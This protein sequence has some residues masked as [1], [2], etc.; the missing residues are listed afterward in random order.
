MYQEREVFNAA[1][2][3]WNMFFKSGFVVVYKGHLAAICKFH[4]ISAVYEQK[5]IKN[6]I[7]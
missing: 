1:S 3:Y 6:L 4:L 2:T 7:V 5:Q